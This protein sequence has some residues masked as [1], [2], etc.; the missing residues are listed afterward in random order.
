VAGT[1]SVED[2]HFLRVEEAGRR[3]MRIAA[4]KRGLMRSLSGWLPRMP[5]FASKCHLSRHLY[6]DARGSHAAANRVWE[7]QFGRGAFQEPV[8][9][10]PFLALMDRAEDVEEMLAGIYL[11]VKAELSDAYRR[12]IAE[13]DPV[14]DAPTLD[15]LEPLIREEESQIAW[16]REMLHQRMLSASRKRELADWQEFLGQQLAACGGVL[17]DAAPDPAYQAP[18]EFAERPP[19]RLPEAITFTDMP[20]HSV[21]ADPGTIPDNH[22]LV[23]AYYQEID[24]VDLLATILFD[25]PRDM[26][27]AYYLDIARQTWDESRHTTMGIRRL[28]ELGYDLAQCGCPTGRYAAF[29]RMTMLERLSFLT[30]V[31]EACSLAGKREHIRKWLEEGDIASSALVEFDISDESQHV[32]FGSKWMPELMKRE[33]ETRSRKEMAA[34]ASLR[35][36]QEL[37]PLKVA[38]GHTIPDNYLDPFGGCEEVRDPA[39]S[40]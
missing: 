7:L 23:Y 34:H 29:Q 26:P 38:A 4:L 19:Y 22:R 35:Y 21:E 12:Y 30:Q 36:R 31:G 32:R 28:H 13:T 33:G 39:N 15:I 8:E 37:L 14:F 6:L 5:D 25:S 17:G 1:I 9:L 18:A 24:I 10:E 20:N 16:A 27:S 2:Q 3:L 40:F 11:T